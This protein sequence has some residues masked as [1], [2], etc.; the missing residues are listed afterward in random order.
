MATE[1]TYL[2]DPES[3]E[4]MARL[5]KQGRLITRAIGLFPVGVDPHQLPSIVPHKQRVP[6]LLDIGCGPGAWALDA[7][8]KYPALE[9]TGVDVSQ[10]MVRYANAEAESR[11]QPNAKFL[12]MN[13]LEPLLFANESFDLVH[14]RTAVSFIPRE[15]WVSVLKECWRILRPGGLLL[16]VEGESGIV[17]CASPAT[18]QSLHWLAQALWVQGLGFWDGYSTML[19]IH[20]MQGKL[21]ADAGF[22]VVQQVPAY[23]DSSYG[24]DM[25]QSSLDQQRVLIGQIEPLICNKLGVSKETFAKIQKEHIRETCLDSF[26]NITP[27]LSVVGRKA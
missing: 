6:Q 4:E 11:E 21:V 22:Q 5:M 23:I 8:A 25:Y 18:G 17:T 19:G 2:L 14:I 1:N 26:R 16:S 12:A 27:F 15:K 24:S 9:I 13:V 3:A 20:A 10:L 7:A